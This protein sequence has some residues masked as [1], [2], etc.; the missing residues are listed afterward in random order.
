MYTMHDAEISFI[1]QPKL[2]KK[3]HFIKLKKRYNVGLSAPGHIAETARQTSPRSTVCAV[4]G[5]MPYQETI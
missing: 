3:M 5:V 4:F 2:P 1:D